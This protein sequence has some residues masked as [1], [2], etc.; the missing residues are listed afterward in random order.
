MPRRSRS[1]AWLPS[2]SGFLGPGS[3]NRDVELQHGSAHDHAHGAPPVKA[4]DWAP[5]EPE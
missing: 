1:L 3:R 4:F 2:G 5:A